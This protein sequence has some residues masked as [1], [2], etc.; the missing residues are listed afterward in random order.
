MCEYVFPRQAMYAL[1]SGYSSKLSAKHDRQWLSAFSHG[2]VT[3]SL[4]MGF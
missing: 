1:S 2:A 3:E 4:A